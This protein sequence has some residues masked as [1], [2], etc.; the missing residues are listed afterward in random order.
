MN[1]RLPFIFVIVGLAL[2]IGHYLRCPSVWHDEAALILNVIGKDYGELLGSL[3]HHEAG[4]PLFLWIEHFFS[5]TFGD[6]VWS[7]RFPALFVSCFA[8]IAFWDLCRRTLEERALPWAVL[9]FAVSD[10]LLWH[11]SEAKPYAFDV[12]VAVLLMQSFERT[13]SW[14]MTRQCLLWM[15]ILPL[16]IWLSYPACF[17]SGGVIVGLLLRFD[18]RAAGRKPA[19]KEKD[20]SDSDFT[21]DSHGGLTPCRSPVEEHGG[22]TPSPVEEHGGLTPCRSP[23]IFLIAL[24]AIVAVSFLLLVMGPAKAQRDGAMESCWTNHFPDW[25]RPWMFPIWSLFS[26]LDLLRYNLIPFGQLLAG[27]FIV[28]SVI[29]WKKREFAWLAVLLV[30]G[31]LVFFASCM[32]KYPYGGSRL[33]IFLAPALILMVATGIPAAYDWLQQRMPMGRCVLTALLLMPA[34]QAG[35]RCVIDWPRADCASAAEYVLNHRKPGEALIINHWEFEYY[36][37]RA[38]VKPVYLHA[39]VERPV[40]AWVV[41]AGDRPEER[42]L[43]ACMPGAEIVERCEFYRAA[44]FRVK[45]P[46]LAH[47]P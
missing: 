42:D 39:V 33:E 44:A 18:W 38:D 5:E 19:V 29:S 27:L 31:I 32:N 46:Q 17:L 6:G 43:S 22:L 24:I 34:F 4:P 36:F 11:A 21:L 23:W 14:S 37:R 10:R 15:P 28:G 45:L 26:S 3:F 2:R 40:R 30:P 12:L 25:S 16:C 35:Y 47:R 9:L 20:N 8:L 7:L 13:Q 1:Q 41:L